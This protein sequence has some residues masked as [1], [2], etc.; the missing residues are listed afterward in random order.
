MDYVDYFENFRVRT[1]PVHDDEW[2]WRQRQFAC[3]LHSALLAAIGK[4][5]KH[6]HPFLDRSTGTLRGGWIVSANVFN[7][8]SKAGVRGS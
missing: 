5:S 4:L 2:Q 6:I 8:E 1:Y 7:N 3:A